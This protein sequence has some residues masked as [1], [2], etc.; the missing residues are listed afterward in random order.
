MFKARSI[1]S[2]IPRLH[3]LS[4]LKALPHSGIIGFA[5]N[6]DTAGPPLEKAQTANVIAIR[7][8]RHRL[9]PLDRPDHAIRADLWM[10]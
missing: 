3:R 6:A 2:A 8:H 9:P 4:A 10:V 7:Q 1:K 5:A